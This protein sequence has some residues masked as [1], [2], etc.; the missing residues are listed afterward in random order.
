MKSGDACHGHFCD[1]ERMLNV[2]FKVSFSAT[3][4]PRRPTEIVA[5]NRASILLEF[6]SHVWACSG[7]A[8]RQGL[9]RAAEGCIEI[10]RGS[11]LAKVL[12]L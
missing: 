11:Q 2:G 8:Q 7:V 9:S 10:L 4:R 6:A 5:S 3:N 12:G 1:F